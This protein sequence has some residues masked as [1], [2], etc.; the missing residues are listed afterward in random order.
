MKIFRCTAFIICAVFL[1]AGC[2]TSGSES[3]NSAIETKLDEF[4]YEE[5]LEQ[6]VEGTPG[7]KFEGFVN[8]SKKK[9]KSVYDAEERA[10]E[11][12]VAL[13]LG[14]TESHKTH[15]YYDKSAK[16]WK[17]VFYIEGQLGGS[18]TVYMTDEGITTLIV[19]GE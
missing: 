6:Y 1:L 18:E 4:S 16:M 17:V 15:I 7:V 10:V 8:T 12:S 3:D 5:D 19:Y 9:I 2:A 13:K 14:I 11:E